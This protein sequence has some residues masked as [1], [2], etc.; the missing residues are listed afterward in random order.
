MSSVKCFQNIVASNLSKQVSN[1]TILFALQYGFREKRFCETQVILFVDE[2]NEF[3]QAGK[4]TE[5]ILL[6]FSKAFDNVAHELLLSRLHY[7]G[8]SGGGDFLDQGLSR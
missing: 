1:E 8:I 4:Q 2:L 5:L 6:D 3:M 7:Y